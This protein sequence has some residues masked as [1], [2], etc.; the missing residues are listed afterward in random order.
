MEV[1]GL[2]EI[3]SKSWKCRTAIGR[4]SKR[5]LLRP[6]GGSCVPGSVANAYIY[7]LYLRG[8]CGKQAMCCRSS[9]CQQ[10]SESLNFALLHSPLRFVFQLW[11]LSPLLPLR[12]VKSLWKPHVMGWMKRW[13]WTSPRQPWTPRCCLREASNWWT[14]SRRSPPR[15]TR[16]LCRWRRPTRMKK[17][18]P[19]SLFRGRPWTTTRCFRTPLRWT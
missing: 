19:A 3:Q 7:I 12:L 6:G 15:I 17:M 16:W 13:M 8:A 18:R 10:T 5:L 4:Q 1:T 14:N 11:L 9:L 2:T